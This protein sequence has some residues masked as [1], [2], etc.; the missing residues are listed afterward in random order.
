LRGVEQS[1]VS[2]V[3]ANPRARSGDAGRRPRAAYH[4]AQRVQDKHQQGN[5]VEQSAGLY[6]APER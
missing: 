1:A 2:F 6:R 3:T 4:G 5:R